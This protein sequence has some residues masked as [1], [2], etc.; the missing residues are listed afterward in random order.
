MTYM[1]AWFRVATQSLIICWYGA[2]VHVG[3]VPL[4][5]S[6]QSSFI[7][8]RTAL[9]FQLL[10]ACTE[11]RS[12]GPSEKPQPPFR[13]HADSI[14]ERLTPRRMTRCPEPLTS[15]LP[16]TWMPENAGAVVGS[17]VGVDAG[18]G[19]GSGPGVAV[20][21]TSL[22]ALVPV[23]AFAGFTS[24]PALGLRPQPALAASKP[25]FTISSL[26]TGGGVGSGVAVG[27]GVGATVGV[28]VGAAV[29]ATVGVAVGAAVGVGVGAGVGVARG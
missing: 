22:S 28:G 14:P 8:T 12:R 18:V 21:A 25:P 4:M 16:W 20:G 13:M 6:Q 7:W 29:G 27:A 24:M 17:G 3:F 26:G 19:V 5:P 15:W 23:C 10:I 9:V 11:A 1:P 2:P